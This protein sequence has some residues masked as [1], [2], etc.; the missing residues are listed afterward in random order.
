VLR[1]IA[2][3][4]QEG[5]R[6]R[7]SLHCGC[8][9]KQDCKPAGATAP[10]Y[11]RPLAARRLVLF[12]QG[13]LFSR[14]S[15]STC[16]SICIC[17]VNFNLQSILDQLLHLQVVKINQVDNVHV[18]DVTLR[19]HQV[20]Q[21]SCVSALQA[22]RTR[23]QR[24]GAVSLHVK[25]RLLSACSPIYVLASVPRAHPISWQSSAMSFMCKHLFDHPYLLSPTQK[26]PGHKSGEN[27]ID[28][29]VKKM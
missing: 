29:K 11:M 2:W 22:S 20:A 27:K 24:R 7:A 19:V 25:L 6:K 5:L 12:I 3:V 8:C 10:K 21:D 18:D 4:G 13:N 28:R 26:I 14:P 15:N 17:L 9:L 16:V 23:A 1:N